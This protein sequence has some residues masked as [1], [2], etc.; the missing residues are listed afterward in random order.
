MGTGIQTEQDL[1][2]GFHGQNSDMLRAFSFIVLA[3]SYLVF[4]E[5]LDHEN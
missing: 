5:E 4:K 2:R 1:G 3:P